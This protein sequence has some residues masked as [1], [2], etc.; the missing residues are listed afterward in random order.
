MTSKRKTTAAGCLACAAV[1]AVMAAAP[2]PLLS[3]NGA[4]PLA[5]TVSAESLKLNYSSVSITKG[6]RATLTATGASNVKWT[7]S[8]PSVATVT[9]TGKVYAIKAGTTYITA[10]SGNLTAVC[11][12]KVVNGKLKSSQSTVNVEEG[13]SQNVTINVSGSHSLKYQVED[14]TVAKASWVKS[15][16]GNNITLKVKG[17][18]EGSTRVKVMMKNYPDVYKY[19][20]INVAASSLDDEEDL[21]AAS[22]QQTV[23]TAHIMP[24]KSTVTIKKGLTDTFKIY[25]NKKENISAVSSDPTVVMVSAPV[26]ETTTNGYAGTYTVTGL[27]SGTASVKVTA[28]DNA[29][30]SGTIT[31]NVTASG[32]Y[33]EVCDTEPPKKT[34]T[35]IMLTWTENGKTKYMLVSSNYD[36]AYTNTIIARSSGKYSYYTVYDSAPEKLADTD[37]VSSFNYTIGGENVKRFILLP[38]KYDTIQN[39][40]VVASYTKKYQYW[41]IYNVKPSVLQGSDVI[42]QWQASVNGQLITRYILLPAGYS[43]SRLENIKKSD[44]ALTSGYYTIS[45]DSSVFDKKDT[46]T[47]ERF[48]YIEPSTGASKY[49]FILLPKDYDQARKDTALAEFTGQYEYYKVYTSSPKQIISTDIIKNWKK[50]INGEVVSRY[51]LLPAGYST[52]DFEKIKTMML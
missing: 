30:I 19:I 12:V 20:N 1:T 2:M 51:M 18:K 13:D 42:K 24:D 33:Y 15:W 41:I 23:K 40:T 8:D 35:D 32:D 46:D 27:K 43:E 36:P 31:V 45:P 7:S 21:P 48:N 25:T 34:I 29:S 16:D 39:Q 44:T 22:E 11:K 37:F 10:R 47:I 50:V 17:L 6:F 38:E 4:S 52:S 28:S 5:L 14:K 9:K 49:A 26:W 3:E